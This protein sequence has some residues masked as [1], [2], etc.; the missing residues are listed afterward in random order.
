[1]EKLKFESFETVEV[2]LCSSKN[3]QPYGRT[4]VLNE[5]NI[6][7]TTP[8]NNRKVIGGNLLAE[9]TP[10]EPVEAPEEGAVKPSAELV[11]EG[12]QEFFRDYERM[13]LAHQ[14]QNSAIALQQQRDILTKHEDI[15]K[16]ML[17]L[18]QTGN[19]D[20][21]DVLEAFP[22]HAELVDHLWEEMENNTDTS[23]YACDCGEK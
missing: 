19:Y 8:G 5:V 16:A 13:M 18:R 21:G 11:K 4:Y 17:L 3:G 2:R 7:E 20:V 12:F 9:Y 6:S 1:M 15:K 14:A 10:D 23:A 22:A